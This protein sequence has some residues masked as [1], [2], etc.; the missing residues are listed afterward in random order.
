VHQF[1]RAGIRPDRWFVYPEIEGLSPGDLQADAFLDLRTQGNSLSVFEFDGAVKPERIAIAVA[2]GKQ[3]PDATGYAIFDRNAVE[4]LGIEI[5]K[6]LGSTA[7]TAVNALHCDL[8]VRT[9]ALLLAL[10]G[11]IAQGTI[12]P[13]LPKHAE[14]LLKAGLESGQLDSNKVN[15]DLR[16][17]LVAKID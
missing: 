14:Q 6:A 17:K 13:I 3:K 9:A 10:A 8:N 11:V 12:V 1:L 15:K 2:A 7:D 5:R 16:K 4:A